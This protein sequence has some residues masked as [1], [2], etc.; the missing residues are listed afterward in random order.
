MRASFEFQTRIRNRVPSQGPCQRKTAAAWGNLTASQSHSFLPERDR[1][2]AKV[3]RE[4]ALKA[5]ALSPKAA[6]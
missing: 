2:S 3:E 6:P 4:K 1:A 5:A